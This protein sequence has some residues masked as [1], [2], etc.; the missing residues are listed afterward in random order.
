MRSACVCLLAV[1]SPIANSVGATSSCA[2]T[3]QDSIA[4]VETLE[5]WFATMQRG[6]T[7]GASRLMTS[8]FYAYDAGQRFTRPAFLLALEQARAKGQ[9]FEWKPSAFD[10]H[11]S[12]GQAWI[13]YKNTGGVR[14]SQGFTPLIWLESAALERS[15]A[16]WRLTFL[17]ST[18]AEH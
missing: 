18:A 2:T 15:G 5:D 10:V 3:A 6:D 16:G 14:T 4:V 17:H 8:T 13:A 7:P 12:C 9:R 11:V 1:F